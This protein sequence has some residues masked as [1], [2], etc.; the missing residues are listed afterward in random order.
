M[1]KSVGCPKCNDSGYKGRIGIFEA[2]LMNSEIEHILAQNPG[3]NEIKKI[4][5]TQGLL[6]LAQ[7]GVIKILNGLTT[8]EELKRVVDLD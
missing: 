2:I 5:K 6:T 7:D 4:F 3:K 1:Y 8:M